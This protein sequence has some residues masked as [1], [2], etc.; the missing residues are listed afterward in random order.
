MW[1]HVDGAMAGSAAV[2]PELRGLLAGLDR[3]D[4]FVFN[5]HKWLFTTFDCSC[6]YVADRAALVDALSILPEYLRNAASESG[7]VV[8]YRDWQVPLGRRFRALKLWFVLR[9][10]GAEGLRHHVREHVRLAGE[11]A[12]R[13]E[14]DPRL[15][16]AAPAGLNLVCFRHVDGDD[17][18]EAL[19]AGAQRHGPGV[20][21]PHPAGRPLRDP[22]QHRRLD[23]RAAPRRRPLGARST[24]WPDAGPRPRPRVHRRHQA[25]S[26]DFG[27]SRDS[28]GERV[29][30]WPSWPRS[31]SGSARRRGGPTASTRSP[32]S[33][34]AAP[35]T[36]K[37]STSRAR[38]TPTASRS[39]SSPRR[40]TASR[41][42]PPPSSWAGSARPACCT[43][44]AC[45]PATTTP[46]RSSTR[47]PACP[48]ARP[49]PGCRRSTPSR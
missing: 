11:L 13:I 27:L 7:A 3:A 16:L 49:R 17:A 48:T 36:P 26:V 22:G 20:P 15:E 30:W 2:C 23:D 33:P 47:S 8:D 31:R 28:P 1:L 39:R 43:S 29:R 25:A 19:H 10:Y 34:A 24:I 42:R 9:W 21:H 18:T 14:A 45:G 41:R 37:T 46:S 32:S 5:P 12:A 44:R 6:F 40:P 4:S 35:A 38:S